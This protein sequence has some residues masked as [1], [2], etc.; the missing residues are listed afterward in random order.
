MN[1]LDHLLAGV[2]AVEHLGADGA[3]TDPSDE[4]L[5]DAEVDVGLEQCEADLAHRGVDICLCDAPAAA[6][7]AKDAAQSFRKIIKHGNRV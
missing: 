3:L 6:Q 5:D 1:D 4:V 2:E 7:P